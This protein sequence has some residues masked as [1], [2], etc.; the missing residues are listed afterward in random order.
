M[1]D[2][3]PLPSSRNSCR[4]TSALF[5]S[6]ELSDSHLYI[7][8]FVRE[9]RQ[10]LN[11]TPVQLPILDDH[12]L[13]GLSDGETILVPLS[14]STLNALASMTRQLDS[15]TTQIGNITAQLGTIQAATH[16]MPTWTA[17]EGVLTPINAAIRDLSHR[18]SAPAPQAP[19][20][21]RPPVPP[22]GATTRQA[23]PPTRPVVPPSG[24][25]APPPPRPKTRAPP[26]DRAPSASF[27]PDIPRYDV[28][29][30]SFYGDP[31]AYADKF[32]DS[33]E[34]NAFREGKYPDP[35]TFIAGHLAPDCPKPQRSYAK[36]ASA[37]A[38]KGKKNKG[39]LTAAQVA[40]ASNSV[41][42]SQPPKSLPT[43]ERRFYAPR[44]SPSEHQQASLIAASFPDIA[45]RVLRDAN[46]ILPLAVTTKV[47][48]R[49]SVTLLVSDPT[50]PAAALAP[51]FDALSAQLNKSFPVGESPWLPFRLAP[52]EAQLAIHSLPIAF[53]PE[54][55]E[56]LL[57]CLAESIL[58]SK[59]IRILAARYLNP[60][61]RSREGK[62]ATSVII[63]VHPGDVPAMGSSIRLFSRSRTVER[64]YSSNR[65]TQCKN[66][67]GFGHVAPRCPSVVPVC[68]I[69]SLNH[70]RAMHR[71]PNPT[72]PGGGNLKATPGC[73]SSSPP[74]CA[75]C[76]G[77]H[78]ATHRDCDSRPSPPTLRRSTAAET[79]V[80]PPPAGDEMDTDADV[81]NLSPP[82]SPTRSLQ[83]AFEMATPR[84]RSSTILPASVG[85]TQ[86]SRS[87]PPVEPVSPSPM[88]RNPSGLAR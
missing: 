19:A 53:L 32:P 25:H 29:T 26:P 10:T 6:P 81:D 59:N 39:S 7:R 86:G 61:T 60:D 65:Y 49:G 40:S 74:R 33:W 78:T 57:P 35:T 17:L 67:W 71:C 82:A 27:D 88:S 34:A 14:C 73:C 12:Q 87:L 23:P 20:P 55:P 80:L 18:V 5:S 37:G 45:A 24:T 48:D 11:F 4:P 63:S 54:D 44:S 41:P 84:A 31:R 85:P 69:C 68:P 62:S 1:E 76:E 66:C 13:S 56:E 22:T 47:N 36:V 51:Y 79:I 2:L 9:T 43:A 50:T 46:C 3:P 83:S 42:A 72:C 77:A 64:A 52:N 15:I 30:R 21:T 38:P 28:D 16:T 75:N 58:N 8:D 70:T